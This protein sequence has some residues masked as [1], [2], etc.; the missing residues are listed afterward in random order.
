MV[1]L[2]ETEELSCSIYKKPFTFQKLSPTHVEFVGCSCTPPR[3]TVVP[4]GAIKSDLG[5][6]WVIR[7][8]KLVRIC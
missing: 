7:C 8:P 1:N 6:V 5:G 4:L 3:G 2:T